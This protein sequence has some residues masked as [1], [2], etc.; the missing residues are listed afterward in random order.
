VAVA[1]FVAFPDPRFALRATPRPVDDALRAT[2]DRLLAAAVDAQAYGLAAPHIGEV[3]PVIVV[4]VAAPDSR[5]YRVFYNPR[6]VEVS[7]DTEIGAEGSVSLPGAQVE[8][9]R[10]VWAE[11]AYDDAEGKSHTQRF[12]SFVARCVLHETEQVNGVFFLDHLSRLKREM[13]LKRLRK[14]ARPA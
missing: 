13:L 3:A 9:A 12:E 5:D 6:I 2:G 1:P 7:S 8:I 11:L 10:P 4:S 14:A